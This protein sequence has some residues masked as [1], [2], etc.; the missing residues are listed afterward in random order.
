MPSPSSA[1]T[2]TRPDLA[3]SF[4]EF[5]L[6][7][8]REGFIWNRVL[9]VIDVAS[10]AN[11]FGII[12][13][14]QLLQGGNTKRGSGSGYSRGNWEFEPSSY[15]T[16]ENG[17]EEPVD[18]RDAKMYAN[19]FDAE[20]VSAA[21]ALGFVLRS[22]EQRVAD[23]VFNATTFNTTAITNEW[24]DT[25]NAV[26]LTD[27]EA[28]VQ[29][30]W[31]ATGVWPNALIINRKVFRNL[32]NC[33]QVVDRITASGAGSPAKASDVTVEMLQA[34]FDLENVIVAGNS[35]NTAN[36]GQAASISQ[37]WSDEYAMVTRV[38]DSADF[39]DPCIGRTFHWSEDGS[40]I[41]GTVETYREEQSR[42]DIVRVRHDTDEKILYPLIG[43]LLSNVT[44]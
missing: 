40:M 7:N 32:R 25:A 10:S 17:W 41:G 1:L 22:A 29:R 4:M 34:A 6:M 37:I 24:D 31:S 3:D 19:Y 44:T 21:R 15:A 8:A 27:V 12:P 35:K 16:Q 20:S 36:E 28:A 11:Q 2:T 39:R 9:S 33:S 13:V 43:E 23:L 30:V 5:D 38:S 14:E 26:P 42:S 18:D